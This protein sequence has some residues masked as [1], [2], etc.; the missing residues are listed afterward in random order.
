MFKIF[1]RALK[2]IT[3]YKWLLA[4]TILLSIFFMAANVYFLPLVRDIINEISHKNLTHFNNQILNLL[5]LYL[6][7]I[8]S[9]YSISY[10][11]AYTSEKVSIDIRKVLYHKLLSLSQH[12]YSTWKLGDILTRLFSDVAKMKDTITLCFW[13]VIPQGIT[14]IGIVTYLAFLNWKLSML[15]FIATPFFIWLT[16]YLA[17]KL[18]KV[19][20]RLQRKSANLTHMAQEIISNIKLVQV[21]TAEKVEEN[22]FYDENKQNFRINM[23]GIRFRN[24]IEGL[25]S[26]LQFFVIVGVIWYGGYEIARG[27]MNGPEL[28]S[29]FTGIFLLIDPVLALSKVYTNIQQ[30]MAST[31]RI[32]KILDTPLAIKNIENPVSDFRI[33]GKVRFN[34]VS[35]HYPDNRSLVLKKISLE[36][37]PGEIIALVGLSGVGKST[38]V[39]LIPRFFDPT[40]GNIE[41]DNQELKNIDL[42]TLRSQI[43]MVPQEDILFRGT[44]LDNISYGKMD[45]SAEEVK[46]AA[47]QANAWEFIER[48]PGN[49]YARIQD[50]GANLSGGQ[51]Q[52][53]SIA[54]AILRNPRILILDEAT[55]SL[56]T[57]SERLVQEA[58]NVLMKQRTTFVIA[59][60]LS[61]IMHADK[62][63]VMDKGTIRESGKH[64]ELLDRN[65]LYA[66]LYHLQFESN[67]NQS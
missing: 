48:M 11:M 32:Y 51:K 27:T 43:G 39:N 67:K 13:E 34:K 5:A 56:D 47:I 53:I 35:F 4:L 16:M 61:T 24:T 60:R 41:I 9:Q 20:H 28:V 26:C 38:L 7:R 42:F 40:S 19:A 14:F 17:N 37:E 63:I 10:V 59:H 46:K 44:V 36:A 21:Y 65:E 54:R 50:R 6:L 29:F 58:L 49:L 57:E 22:R 1:K 52:R 15:T 2:F 30:S 66:K 18:R 45:A 25:I 8:I 55:S 64:Q 23:K 31:Q 12:F 33:K 3:P 62:I